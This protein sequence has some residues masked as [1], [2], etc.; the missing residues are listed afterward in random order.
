VL[1]EICELP[2]EQS[3]ELAPA[4]AAAAKHAAKNKKPWAA[5]IYVIFMAKSPS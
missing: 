1:A 5:V 3:F 2:S 4:C